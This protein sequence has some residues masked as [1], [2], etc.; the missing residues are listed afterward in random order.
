MST[1]KFLARRTLKFRR[2]TRALFAGHGSGPEMSGSAARQLQ[3]DVQTIE[4]SGLFSAAWYCSQVPGLPQRLAAQHYLTHGAA[5]GRRP[6]P[7]FDGQKYLELNADVS[8]A[9]V[10]PLLHW[11]RS[12]K[13]E[14]RATPLNG[15]S[16]DEQHLLS[17]CNPHAFEGPAQISDAEFKI[18]VITP[19]YNTEPKLL[20]ELYVTLANQAYTHWEWCVCDDASTSPGTL[21]TLRELAQL[22][23]RIK[24]VFAPS[25][26]G[27]SRA[28]NQALSIATGTHIALVDHDDLLN[29]HAFAA[30]YECWKREQSDIFYTDECKLS[31]DGRLYD[32]Y[33]KPAWSPSYLENTM[34]IGH[35]TVYAAS[36]LEVTGNFRPEYDGTQ[37]YDLALRASRAAKSVTHVP[38]VGYLW[39]AIPGSTAT[40]LGEK[41]YALDRQRAAVHDHARS[42]HPDASVTAGGAPGLWSI[43]YPAPDDA[44]LMS[45]VMPTG[46][47]R[48][49]IRG[50]STDLITNC[51]NSIVK[52]QFYPNA[53]FIIVHNGNLTKEHK[54]YIAKFSRVTLVHYEEEELNLARKMNLG[55]AAARG[56]YVCLLN[57]DIEIIDANGGS[58]I[59]GFMESHPRVGAVAPM[60]LFEDGRVQHNGVILLEQGPSH[61][62]IFQSPGY[63]GHFGNLLCRREAFGVTGAMLFCR[64]DDYLDVG[65]FEETLPLNYNDVDFCQKLQSRGKSAVV[66][67]YVKVFHFESASKVGTFRCEKETLMVRWPGIEDRYF[68]K[69][70]DQRNPY[71]EPR[72]RQKS[73]AM[74]AIKFENWLDRRISD[75][76]ELYPS[77]GKFKISVCVPVYN[78]TPAQLQELYVSFRMQTY[79]NK[80][81]VFVDDG[82]TDELT[83]LW[84]AKLSASG[85]VRKV[86]LARNGGIAAASRAMLEACTGEYYLPVDADDFL[87]IDALSI[88]AHHIE[89]N[90]DVEIFYSDEFKSNPQSEKFAPFLKPDFDP[91]MISNACYVTHL[92]AFRTATMRALGAYSDDRATWCHDWDSTFRC[93][94][95]GLTPM[96]VPELLYA[97]RINPGST[98]SV[99]SGEK[100]AAVASQRFVLER[101]LADR[102]LQNVLTIEPNDVRPLT[103][104]W[105][106]SALKAVEAE[107]IDGAWLWG[108]SGAERER[109]FQRYLSVSDKPWFHI[110]LD[111]SDAERSKL[112]LSGPA[113]WDR[114]VKGVS[115][116]LTD[117]TLET[118]VWAGGLHSQLGPIDPQAG[119]TISSGGHYGQ[120]FCQRSVDVLAPVNVLLGR[121][122]IEAMIACGH[123]REPAS[124]FMRQLAVLAIADDALLAVTPHLVSALPQSLR[125]AIPFMRDR[126]VENEPQ[127]SRWLNA[128]ADPREP[129]KLRG[130]TGNF[131]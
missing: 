61:S 2:A 67:P 49:M 120:A 43:T 97:W 47:G 23:G 125:L 102:G 104:T 103:G 12:G 27:I 75:R 63:H 22:D 3:N 60:C 111:L 79:S 106:L 113:L 109:V 74:D 29:R 31:V 18:S 95:A 127:A 13:D 62:G 115:G 101:A 90:P 94:A 108:L 131:A 57:D 112:K 126:T 114:R 68:N 58:N 45:Y 83:K 24:I 72:K 116:L 40:N 54:A 25:N 107:D 80:E 42:L 92:M 86:S 44:P 48:R 6:S 122:L 59:I 34:Y 16:S 41:S 99:E 36:V 19:T 87:T 123:G 128:F 10:N 17:L 8:A 50:V 64:R 84:L 26:G 121:E 85:D 96:H 77:L 88:M 35:L 15:V 14:S 37:D 76:S 28:S 53:E 89:L 100:P 4:N 105:K 46:A 65:G 91:V 51:L 110:T 81:I 21:S 52:K 11:I 98:A 71:Y 1:A 9:G 73:D 78:Q 55:V 124:V 82:S 32:F 93:L 33:Y 38:I 70:F 118:I 117:S 69:E 130:F 20:R 5:E 66:D 56:K 129:A 7:Y 39:R 119:L 30:I